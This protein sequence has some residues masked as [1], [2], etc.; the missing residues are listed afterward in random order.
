MGSSQKEKAVSHERIVAIAAARIRQHGIDGISVA[1]IMREAGLTHGGFY[2]HFSSRDELVKE[3]L[4][5]AL[6]E[7]SVQY[8]MDPESFGSRA[9][10][11]IIKAYL[12]R[13]HRDS[14]ATGC[15]ISALAEDMSRANEANRALYAAQ[16]E[17]D[18]ELLARLEPISD[19]PDAH[20][21]TL[22]LSALVG[23][24]SI[25][26]AVGDPVLSRRVLKE[27]ADALMA[28]IGI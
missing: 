2:R 12:S 3:A 26:R 27:T 17:E 10:P 28:A 18:I 7:G 21:A 1:D 20:L 19:D 4:A 16:V 6:Q 15:A 25:A 5:L 22:T 14:P 11:S 9:L 24:L 8:G 23:A 13:G